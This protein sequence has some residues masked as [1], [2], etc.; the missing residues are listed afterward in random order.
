MYTLDPGGAFALTLNFSRLD[1]LRPGYGY[2]GLPDPN[3]AVRRPADDGVFRMDLRTGASRLILSVERAAALPWHDGRDTSD[4]WHYFNHLLVDP[5]GSRFLVLHRYRERF[6]P[7]TRTFR[8]PFRTRA[9]TG[10]VDGGN[11]HVLDPS[12]HTSHFI[13]DDADHV[14]AW[15]RPLGRPRGFYRLTDR[16][17]HIEPVGPDVMPAN[18]HNTYLP[19]PHGHW[20][21]NDTYPAR[22]DRRQTVYLVDTRKLGEPRSNGG[23]VDLAR[24]PSPPAYTGPWRCDTHPRSNNA[25]TQVCVDSPHRNGRQMYLL[26]IADVVSGTR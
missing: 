26:D 16:S 20:I 4:A 8:G 11:L 22:S 9:L 6:D 21:L 13:W 5:T 1:N 18:G 24:L 3:V 17:D 14:T 10:D 25:G 19:S 2:A 15:T 7:S 12:G 23:R